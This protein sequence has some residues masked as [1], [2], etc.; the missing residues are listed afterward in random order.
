MIAAEALV[1]FTPFT[2][3]GDDGGTEK[4]GAKHVLQVHILEIDRYTS[5]EAYY[6]NFIANNYTSIIYYT[7]I[8]NY[9]SVTKRVYLMSLLS[10]G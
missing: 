6:N 4:E 10:P 1:I 7:L 3:P 8:K 2:L 5:L 9:K